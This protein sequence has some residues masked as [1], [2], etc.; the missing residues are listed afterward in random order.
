ML[1]GIESCGED[2]GIEA[3]SSSS[4]CDSDHILQGGVS[5]AA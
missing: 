2:D 4:D 5:A 1:A 3:A